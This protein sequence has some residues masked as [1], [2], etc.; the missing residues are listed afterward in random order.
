MV[1]FEHDVQYWHLRRC[2]AAGQ[3]SIGAGTF[4]TE[5]ARLICSEILAPS[6]NVVA[7]ERVLR[8]RQPQRDGLVVLGDEVVPALMPFSRSQ[9]PHSAWQMEVDN[10]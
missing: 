4:T 5:Q 10:R 3:Q 7:D 9:E 6:G 2:E 1:V 8:M